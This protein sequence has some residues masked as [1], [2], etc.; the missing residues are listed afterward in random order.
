MSKMYGLDLF[1]I[2]LGFIEI[3]RI[4]FPFVNQIQ[5]ANGGI[6]GLVVLGII[7]YLLANKWKV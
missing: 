5:I 3:A 2:I 6:S 1:L 4:I 7:F